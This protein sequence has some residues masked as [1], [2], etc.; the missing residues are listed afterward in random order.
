[1]WHFSGN[2]HKALCGLTLLE[3]QCCHKRVNEPVGKII[4]TKDLHWFYLSMLHRPAINH[5]LLNKNP[6]QH[7][8]MCFIIRMTGSIKSM[9]RL[10]AWL[11]GLLWNFAR[12]QTVNRVLNSITKQGSQLH[13]T[14]NDVF[15]KDDQWPML[16]C[17]ISF[18]KTL[19][20]FPKLF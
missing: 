16:K 12:T 14:A 2:T 13:T 18:D 7:I 15:Q 8:I 11:P 9:K 10:K 5:R 20:V 6:S 4:Q 1:M 3:N 17:Q 19:A